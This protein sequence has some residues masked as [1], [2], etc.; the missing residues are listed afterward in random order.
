MLGY[1]G[2][3]FFLFEH[4][5]DVIG[6]QSHSMG[7]KTFGRGIHGHGKWSLEELG[8]CLPTICIEITT[9]V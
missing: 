1:V 4:S 8:N 2:I 9:L 3:G 7:S 6:T 5:H